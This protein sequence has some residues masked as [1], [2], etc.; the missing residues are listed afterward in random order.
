MIDELRSSSLD[1]FWSKVVRKE[2]ACW[3][4][5]GSRDSSGY[6]TL[7]KHKEPAHRLSYRLHCGDI[8]RGMV[9]CHRC[10]NPPCT[11]PDH[12]FLGTPAENSAD[13]V[14]KGRSNRGERNGHA[15]LTEADVL[16]IRAER[17]EGWT[18]QA[19]ATTHGLSIPGVHDIVTRRRWA[20]V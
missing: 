20:H 8:P 6:A 9:V 1:S 12:L 5:R 19:I 11:N 10:D 3:E 2:D 14:R 13:M 17:S 16:T 18:L 7:G 4:W 15:R